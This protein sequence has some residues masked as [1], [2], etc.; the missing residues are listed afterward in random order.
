MF[1]LYVKDYP[2]CHLSHL[3]ITENVQDIPVL[4]TKAVLKEIDSS[5]VIFLLHISFNLILSLIK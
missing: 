1:I 5:S 2:V 4:Q 3:I